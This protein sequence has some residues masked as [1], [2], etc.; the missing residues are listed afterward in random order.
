MVLP[1]IWESE[2][3]KSEIPD[4]PGPHSEALSQTKQNKEVK[5]MDTM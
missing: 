1:S 4:Q 3:G 2:A 5:Q